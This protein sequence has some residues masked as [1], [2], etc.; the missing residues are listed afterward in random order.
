MSSKWHRRRR[1]VGCV[2]QF[3]AASESCVMFVSRWNQQ[4]PQERK[5]MWETMNVANVVCAVMLYKSL[6]L[7]RALFVRSSCVSGLVW[8]K[9]YRQAITTTCFLNTYEQLKRSQVK[10]ACLQEQ[11]AASVSCLWVCV[12]LSR[13]RRLQLHTVQSLQCIVFV[14]LVF[15]ANTNDC[16]RVKCVCIS[17]TDGATITRW[18]DLFCMRWFHILPQNTHVL[19]G[20]H[21]HLLQAKEIHFHFDF[22]FMIINLTNV[23]I[24]CFSS[25]QYEHK[26][27]YLTAST[28][29]T[30][31]INIHAK[32]THYFTFIRM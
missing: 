11:A 5:L 14:D 19:L 21:T 32:Y 20:R 31:K 22:F 15:V 26:W 23:S 28:K 7:T 10:C 30:W 18:P 1:E 4:L 8:Y 25:V 16:S 9:C 29:P 12:L 3:A 2:A 24:L 13:K 17:G 27:Q 6:C